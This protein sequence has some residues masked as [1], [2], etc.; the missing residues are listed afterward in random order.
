MFEQFTINF[1]DIFD[2][3]K[4][5]DLYMSGESYAGVYI[6]HIAT[7]L[8][9]NKDIHS[10]INLQGVLIGNGWSNPEIQSITYAEFAYANGI[11]GVKEYLQ[12]KTLNNK[13][14][15]DINQYMNTKDADDF[16]D[17]CGQIVDEIVQ[18]SGS[19]NS[20]VLNL[21]DIRLYDSTHG[22][23]WPYNNYLTNEYLNR[24]DVQEATHMISTGQSKRII[25]ECNDQVYDH[26][27]LDEMLLVSSDLFPFIN[28]NIRMIIYNG[29]FDFIC[30]HYGTS[31]YLK[32][33]DFDFQQEYK[34]QR[35]MWI[36]NNQTAG[37]S[38][39]AN[40]NNFIYLLGLGGSHMYP[41]DQPINALDMLSRFMNNDTFS[42][43]FYAMNEREYNLNDENGISTSLFII[44][45]I[46]S[47]ILGAAIMYFVHFNHQK[48]SD[49][50]DYSQL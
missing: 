34:A 38:R 27:Q 45:I 43:A 20:T 24:Q 9:K 36:V 48:S 15:N 37:Y 21:Y 42:D 26:L 50:Q 6:P 8:I 28:D 2:S 29:Q 47:L 39:T 44:S 5:R 12:L 14:T 10:F 7:R 46:I 17:T 41:M 11:I 22:N 32:Q 18:V 13:C 16:P 35:Y 25:T 31:E 1:F 23:Q 49:D 19:P 4:G 30:N 33:I 40:H 3:F